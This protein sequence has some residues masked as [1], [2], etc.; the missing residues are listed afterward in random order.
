MKTVNNTAL[1]SALSGSSYPVSGPPQQGAGNEVEVGKMSSLLPNSLARNHSFLRA[2]KSTINRNNTI[3]VSF[4]KK[5]LVSE[6]TN[7]LTIQGGNM[8]R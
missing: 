7:I 1:K 2:M 6:S 5:S 4:G 3:T 8:L